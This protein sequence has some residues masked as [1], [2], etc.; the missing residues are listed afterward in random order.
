MSRVRSYELYQCRQCG[1]AQ[2]L[3]KTGKDE[4]KGIYS[5][6]FFKPQKYEDLATLNKENERRFNL[7]RQFIN[8]PKANVLE[9]G[10]ATGD[11]I[12]YAE[13]E[14]TMWGIDVSEAA[15]EK[16]KKKALLSGPR[17][18]AGFIEDAVYPSGF[19]E[20]IVLWD[21]IEHVRD[22][23]GLLNRL[24]D[25]LK[26]G[27]HLFLS[28]PNFGS[29]AARLLGRFW[30][31]MTPPEH[32]SFFT[33]KSLEYFSEHRLNCRLVSWESQGRWSNVGF[34]FYKWKRIFPRLIPTWW[35]KLFQ[36]PLT[37]NW[38]FYVPT[39]DIQYGVLEKL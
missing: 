5:E 9:V 21:V 36:L 1:F 28:T 37:R 38:A 20:G 34:I 22:P 12:R 29:W 4:I 7:L 10:C 33:R 2:V 39:G 13:D 16:A 25:Y 15:I 32:L 26:P 19:F 23:L 11:F 8:Q 30:W 35:L 6:D 18:R 27:G 14:Y 31:F 24:C 17:L 3:R